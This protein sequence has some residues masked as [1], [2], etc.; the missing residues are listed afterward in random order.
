MISSR[1]QSRTPIRLPAECYLGGEA[2]L[3]TCRTAHRLA[4]FGDPV[5]ARI[6]LGAIRVGAEQTGAQLWAAVVMPDH[7]HALVSAA[8]GKSALDVG[9]CFKRL[10]TLSAREQG[11]SG[12]I[13]QRRIHDRG[14]RTAFE[15]NMEAAVRYVLENPVRADLVEDWSEWQHVFLAPALG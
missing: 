4:V 10:T 12:A 8:P 13:W 7:V 3:L 9:A 2:F 1:W 6:A 5:L 11:V 14:V 15:G